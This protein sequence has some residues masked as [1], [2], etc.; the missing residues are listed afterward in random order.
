MLG[1]SAAGR[2]LTVAV[3]ASLASCGP[4]QGEAGQLGGTGESTTRYQARSGD[5]SID[6]TLHVDRGRVGFV[7]IDPTAQVKYRSAIL[8]AGSDYAEVL[9]FTGAAG[10]W[11]IEFELEDAQATYE[12]DWRS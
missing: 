11:R 10:E 12:I 6:V 8:G 2:L 9:R 7:V 1:P 4:L 5:I 3:L